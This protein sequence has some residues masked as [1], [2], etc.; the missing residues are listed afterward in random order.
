MFNYQFQVL[1]QLYDHRHLDCELRINR[2]ELISHQD[3][4]VVEMK[5]QLDI[6]Y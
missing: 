2:R 3:E 1:S 4:E 5:G 6:D